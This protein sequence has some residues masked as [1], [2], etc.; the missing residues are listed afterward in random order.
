MQCMCAKANKGSGRQ[1]TGRER[2]DAGQKEWASHAKQ[3]RELKENMRCRE[4]TL[5]PIIRESPRVG[6]QMSEC[7]DRVTSKELLSP[8]ATD[9]SHVCQIRGPH[10]FL[11]LHGSIHRVQGTEGL[12]GLTTNLGPDWPHG[13]PLL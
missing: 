10:R 8:A 5:S 9:S 3:A 2:G 12:A 7:A 11:S 1:I 6:V 13:N 4:K